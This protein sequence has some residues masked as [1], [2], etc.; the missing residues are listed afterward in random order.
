M[1]PNPV[2]R[3]VSEH[4]SLA[5]VMKRGF[6]ILMLNGDP[7]PMVAHAPVLLAE[8][9]KSLDLHLARSNAIARAVKDEAPAVFA[10]VGPNAYVSPDWYGIDDQVP[11]W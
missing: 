3:G 8:D 7:V 5:F 11:T 4:Q 1:H 6:G 9:G 2:Y 10:C